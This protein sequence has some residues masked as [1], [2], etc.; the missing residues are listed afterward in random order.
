MAVA[1]MA[2]RT[3]AVVR[4]G[5]PAMAEMVAGRMADQMEAATVAVMRAT[6]AATTMVGR[7]GVLS[8]S[9]VLTRM[10]LLPARA[11]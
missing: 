10:A 9:S 5:A 6:T 7:M 3:R 8:P 11:H 1:I 2:A 4:A